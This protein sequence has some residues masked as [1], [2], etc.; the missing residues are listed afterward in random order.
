LLG[1]GTRGCGLCVLLRFHRS[2]ICIK[3]NSRER[4]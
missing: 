2:R 4:R 1:A 3:L